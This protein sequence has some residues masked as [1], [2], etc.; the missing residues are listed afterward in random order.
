MS[1]D[2]VLH[3]LENSTTNTSCLVHSSSFILLRILIISFFSLLS[4]AN[5]SFNFSR[6]DN[7]LLINFSYL[8]SVFESRLSLLSI[9][10]IMTF[11]FIYWQRIVYYIHS[12]ALTQVFQAYFLHLKHLLFFSKTEVLLMNIKVLKLYS[13]LALFGSV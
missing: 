4:P 3:S 9:F 8:I 2:S 7:I 13:K 5:L 6:S 10:Q 12:L 1:L 11:K